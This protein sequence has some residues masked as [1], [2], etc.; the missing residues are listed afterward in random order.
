MTTAST[1]IECDTFGPIEVAWSIRDRSME[2]D[3]V[4]VERPVGDRLLGR[5]LWQHVDEVAA[6]DAEAR[7]R[8]AS[9]DVHARGS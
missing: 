5:E 8:G 6:M 7:R 1:R 2:L 9:A 3:V 4:Y